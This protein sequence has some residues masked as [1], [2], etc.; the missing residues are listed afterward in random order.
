MD[1]KDVTKWNKRV[2]I[3]YAV[4]IWTMV[5]SYAYISYF[6][7]NDDTSVKKKEEVEE[8]ENPNQVVHQTAHCKTVIVYREDFVPYTTRI[9]N[10]LRSFSAEAERGGRDG[11]QDE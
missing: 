4:G 10:F 9:S 8:P 5:G 6:G 7:R 2:S 11:D 1:F 3:V